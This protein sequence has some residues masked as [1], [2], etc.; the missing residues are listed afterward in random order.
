MLSHWCRRVST[1]PVSQRHEQH[2]PHA[3]QVFASLLPI[4]ADELEVALLDAQSAVIDLIPDTTL[5][6][7]KATMMPQATR[8]WWRGN[9]TCL[10]L[11]DDIVKDIKASMCRS[12]S[13]KGR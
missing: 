10:A 6:T 13:C 3:L 8:P 1:T 11:Y 7:T 5:D 9:E 2:F 4:E 12:R